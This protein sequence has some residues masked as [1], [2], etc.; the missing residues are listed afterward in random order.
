M[1]VGKKD[2]MRTINQN[3]FKSTVIVEKV[4]DL[5]PSKSESNKFRPTEEQPS[6]LLATYSEM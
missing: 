5:K 3:D 6:S 2:E 1:V 4:P